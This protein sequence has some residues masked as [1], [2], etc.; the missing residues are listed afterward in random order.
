MVINEATKAEV[1][2]FTVAYSTEVVLGKDYLS[3]QGKTPTVTSSERAVPARDT[4]EQSWKAQA[5]VTR[6]FTEFGFAKGSV[7][8]GS[9]YVFDAAEC[10][11]E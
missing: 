3:V 10:E 5:A 6:T 2:R 11:F 8:P 9:N 4:I 7:P 1:H